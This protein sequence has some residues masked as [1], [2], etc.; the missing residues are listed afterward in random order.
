MYRSL[1][2]YDLAVLVVA[3]LFVANP[4]MLVSGTVSIVVV[5]FQGLR[6]RRRFLAC[7]YPE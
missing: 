5:Y 4:L 3:S 6:D 2:R 7:R 1:C